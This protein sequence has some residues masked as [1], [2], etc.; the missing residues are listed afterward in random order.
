M[1]KITDWR[2]NG[3]EDAFWYVSG[4]VPKVLIYRDG[5]APAG[6][7]VDQLDVRSANDAGYQAA[8]MLEMLARKNYDKLK[9]NM[10]VA[11]D[12]LNARLGG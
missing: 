12:F 8:W 1:E 4:D 3:Q 2:W 6:D 7:L 5:Q 9:P 11:Y 10:R